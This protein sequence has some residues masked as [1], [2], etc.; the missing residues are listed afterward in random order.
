M[1]AVRHN[2]VGVHLARL[3]VG[4]VHRLHCGQV[5]RDNGLEGAAA[6]DEITLN[7]AQDAAV[8]LHVDIHSE[9]HQVAQVLVGE[10]EDALH[11]D[12]GA[13][14]HV[15]HSVLPAQMR[16]EVVD[17]TFHRLARQQLLQVVHH[18]LRLERVRMIKIDLIPLPVREV[19]AMLVVVIVRQGGHERIGVLLR[20][21]ARHQ[22]PQDDVL[23]RGLAA[24]GAPGKTDHQRFPGRRVKVDL[25][26]VKVWNH[27]Q[28]AGPVAAALRQ[29]RRRIPIP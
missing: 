17:G 15:Q 24:A 22:L 20:G 1:R 2:Q 29:L 13:W 26:E 27:W 9:V 28:C 16:G 10:N 12:D 11:Q 21:E 14:L 7:A 23:H 25:G 19:W 18:Q 5:L 3:H 4:V 8:C 6:V